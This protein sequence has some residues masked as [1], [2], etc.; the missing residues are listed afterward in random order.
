LIEER[1]IT[2]FL[3]SFLQQQV[4]QVLRVLQVQRQRQVLPVR[5]RLRGLQERLVLQALAQAVL[6]SCHR[7]QVPKR[8]GRRRGFAWS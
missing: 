4:L 2:S 6:L 5:A 3:L 1:R 7:Q 8:S